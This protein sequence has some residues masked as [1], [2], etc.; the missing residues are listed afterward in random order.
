MIKFAGEYSNYV[1]LL[2]EPAARACC[3]DSIFYL[4]EEYLKN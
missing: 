1:S 3:P 2:Q 4:K